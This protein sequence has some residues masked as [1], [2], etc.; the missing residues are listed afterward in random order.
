MPVTRDF[1]IEVNRGEMEVTKPYG[2]DTLR[3]RHDGYGNLMD[4]TLSIAR[5]RDLNEAI[6]RALEDYDEER[7]KKL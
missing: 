1:M 7:G 5:A 2:Y 4:V 6:T 3:L